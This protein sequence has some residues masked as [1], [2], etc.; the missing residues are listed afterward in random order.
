MFNLAAPITNL[1]TQSAVVGARPTG[2]GDG[3][4]ISFWRGAFGN[5]SLLPLNASWFIR[6]DGADCT[7]TSPAGGTR[8]LEVWLWKANKAGTFKWH[9]TG[10]LMGGDDIS[11]VDA[12]GGAC[13]PLAMIGGATRL[14]I[15]GSN[16][17]GRSPTYFVEPV[18]VNS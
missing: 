7:L 2:S 4:D 9:L 17:A 8:G 14:C 18:E 16:T 12:S 6:S 3:V 1:E 10:Y 13:G 15:A 11:I 5:G